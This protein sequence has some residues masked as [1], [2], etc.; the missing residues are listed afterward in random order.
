MHRWCQRV[1][2]QSII[3]FLVIFPSVQAFGA[4]DRSISRS[5]WQ[6]E[7]AKVTQPERYQNAN[8]NI[9]NI[10][11]VSAETTRFSSHQ[12]SFSEELS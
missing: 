5:T 10:K 8:L 6:P 1:K 2:K 12:N 7:T 9:L 3:K 11:Q 4:S